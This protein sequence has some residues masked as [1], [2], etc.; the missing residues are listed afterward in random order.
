MRVVISACTNKAFSYGLV[1]LAHLKLRP[2][3]AMNDNNALFSPPRSCLTFHSKRVSY[4]RAGSVIALLALVA[5]IIALPLLQ[6]L[7]GPLVT[8]GEGRPTVLR[9]SPIAPALLRPQEN[10]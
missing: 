6:G 9:D 8:A 3:D 4:G 2:M 1:P 10:G 5:G 7:S